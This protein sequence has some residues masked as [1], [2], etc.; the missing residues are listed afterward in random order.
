ALRLLLPGVPQLKPHKKQNKTQKP[1]A[2]PPQPPTINYNIPKY[3]Q[4]VK[5]N[6][7]KQQK[8]KNI[9]QN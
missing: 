5:K 4:F 2:P 1:H 8:K 7:Q 3:Q 9:H 6:H